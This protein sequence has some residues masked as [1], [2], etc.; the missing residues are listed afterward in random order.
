PRSWPHLAAAVLVLIV[1]ILS[2]ESAVAI[3]VLAAVMWFG[4]GSID[5]GAWRVP[6]LGL[7]VCAVYGVARMAL[8]AVPDSFAQEPTRYMLKE[9]IARPIGTLMIPWNTAVLQ[10]WP[11][12]PFLWAV[13]CVL[14]ASTYAWSTVKAVPLQVVLR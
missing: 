7:A 9:L 2:K 12:V 11:V 4:R 14:A 3:P 10:A 5:N 6:V 1:G 13:G 8:V